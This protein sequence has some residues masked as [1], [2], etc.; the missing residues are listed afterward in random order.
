MEAGLASARLE[1]VGE[2]SGVA[3]T[4]KLGACDPAG[5]SWRHGSVVHEPGKNDIPDERGGRL[6]DRN[7]ALEENKRYQA[8]FAGD[9]AAA[10]RQERAIKK[11]G[12]PRPARLSR[13]P[14]SP[15]R[16]LQREQA[17]RVGAT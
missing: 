16:A 15:G 12:R 13:C 14:R 9:W 5:V 1:G 2:V 10:V 4:S 3:G 17:V 6:C 11:T 8:G 7:G